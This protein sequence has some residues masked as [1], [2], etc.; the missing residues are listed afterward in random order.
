MPDEFPPLAPL[1]SLTLHPSTDPDAI[2]APQIVNTWLTALTTSLANN[3]PL[4]TTLLFL[5]EHSWWRDLAT[6]SWNIACHNSAEAISKYLWQSDAGF[7]DAVADLPG[8]LAPHLEDLGGMRFIQAGFRFR[9]RVGSGRGVVRLAN[10]GKGLWRGWTVYTVL[11]RLDGQDE[12]EARRGEDVGIQPAPPG[13]EAS[14]S[15]QKNEDVQVLVIG[16]GH[17]GLALAAHLQNLGLDYL[18]VDKGSRVGDSWRARYK[19]I[20]LHTPAYTDHY[21]FLKFPTNW[22]RYPDQK[23]IAD[24]MEH[25]A[26]IMELNIQLDTEASKIG[27]DEATGKYVFELK[28][29]DGSARSITAKHAVLASGLFS[30]G[31]PVRPTFADEDSFG[32]QIYHSTVHKSARLIPNVQSKKVTIIGAGTSAHDIAQDF[33]NHGAKSVTLVQRG[34]IYVASLAALEEV[35]LKVWD[36]PG[37]STE[38]ADLLGNSFPWPVVRTLSVGA[39]QM[40]GAIDKELLDALEKAGVA[41]KRGVRGDSIVDHMFVKGGHFYLDQGACQMIIDGRIQVRRCE[42]GVQGYYPAGIILA[43]GTQVESDLVIL[44][45]GIERGGKLVEQ[46]MGKEVVD[47]VGELFGL[48]EAQERIGT[49]R[50]TGVPGFWFTAG[51]FAFSRQYAPTLALQIAGAEWGLSSHRK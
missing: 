25:Y 22:P 9:T 30:E 6:F 4:A 16:A 33:V 36:T 10:V 13:G 35:S 42:G 39:S 48:D 12:A 46:I 26:A 29:K 23:H 32:G 15:I 19:S 5:P 14:S 37:V 2:D 20:R 31:I 47:K 21:A 3:Q 34:E 28:G 45:T 8:A 51:S 41:L 18:V 40:M 17:S 11:E 43:D 1:P 49:W 44:A 24:W 38:D 27:Y 7:T 50:P